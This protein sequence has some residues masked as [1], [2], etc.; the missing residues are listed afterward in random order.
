MGDAHA[1]FSEDALRILRGVRFAAQLGF[2][3]DGVTREGMRLLAPSAAENQ[4]G[5][6]S[7]GADE[8]APVSQAGYAKRS[9]E[10]GDY[11]EFFGV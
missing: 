5:T 3:I 6:D 11:K 7:D 1:R 4:C 10:A 9:V 2:E 8:D